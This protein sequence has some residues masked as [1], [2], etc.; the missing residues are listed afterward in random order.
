MLVIGRVRLPVRVG[1]AIR[2]LSELRLQVSIRSDSM[3]D[4]GGH[5]DN[6]GESVKKSVIRWTS[7]RRA[8]DLGGFSMIFTP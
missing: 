8:R 5:W 6:S 2:K 4:F 1:D 7:A 3:A